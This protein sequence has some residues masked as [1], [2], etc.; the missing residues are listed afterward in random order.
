LDW[1]NKIKKHIPQKPNWKKI[2]RKY[3]KK[4]A[5]AAAVTTAVVTTGAVVTSEAPKTPT[6]PLPPK[7]PPPKQTE[8]PKVPEKPAPAPAPKPA[9]PAPTPAAPTP[10]PTPAAPAPTPAAAPE[11]AP[12]PKPTPA[13]QPA[14]APVPESKPSPASTPAPAEPA[15]SAED[16]KKAQIKAAEKKVA[17]M[18]RRLAVAEADPKFA[19]PELQR[20]RLAEAEAELAALKGSQ[21]PPP[22][23]P[24]AA[25]KPSAVVTNAPPMNKPEEVAE[26][27]AGPA[28]AAVPSGA[29]T[30]GASLA[31]VTTKDNSVELQGMNPGFESVVARMA[32]EFKEKT[33][34]KLLITSGVRSNE[35]QQQLWFSKIDAA[36]GE[37]AVAAAGGG[38]L[39]AGAKKLGITSKVA[40]P[41]APL[42]IDRANKIMAPGKGSKHLLGL[43]IDIN[44]KGEGGINALAGP[45]TASTGWLEKFGLQRPIPNEDWHIEL[46]GAPGAGDVGAV[47]GKNGPTDP[48]SGKAT[49]IPTDPKTGEKLYDASKSVDQLKKEKPRGAET[50]I[51][52]NTHT[53]GVIKH[54]SKPQ[55]QTATVPT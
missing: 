50:V 29:A 52:T 19:D 5:V 18:K 16:D 41:V 6:E 20:Q 21:P 39:M 26:K 3:G 1:L 38:N 7:P 17:T 25:A 33:G 12:A 8:P 44:S 36:G 46:A 40:P 45:R 4:A 53:D 10:A 54:K 27:T 14:P 23:P 42:G 51:V 49:P 35:K 15:P 55:N 28:P 48:G 11:P 13:P 43:A 9:A 47:P 30:G 24:A 31:S 37:D 32:A 2:K 22:P 34:K